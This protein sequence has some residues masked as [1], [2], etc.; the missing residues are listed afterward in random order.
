MTYSELRTKYP[1]FI[2]D[3]FEYILSGNKL[4]IKFHFS[5]PPDHEFTHKLS[6]NLPELKGLNELKVLEVL[7]F[8][9]G[10]SL[11]PSYWKTTC[12][13]IIEI[14]AKCQLTNDQMQFWKKLLI[15]G[16]GEYFYKNQIDFTPPNFLSIISSGSSLSTEH[17]PAGRQ[18]QSLTSNAQ[19]VLV[20]IGG[21]K[22]S[23]VTLELLK[24]HFTVT[25]LGINPHPNFQK[26]TEIAGVDL[27]TVTSE[28]DP[29]LLD[30]NKQGY[31]NGHV[32]VSAFYAFTACLA[33]NL[34]DIPSVVLS[35]ERSSNEGNT[36][37]LGHEINHQYSKS[38]EF[39]TDFNNYFKTFNYF[40][41][42]RPLYELQ[43]TK[44]FSNYPQYFNV[45]TSCN[46]NFK[47]MTDSQRPMTNQ[48]CSKCPKCVS[49]A[50]L[51]TPFIGKNKV[52]EIMGTYPP[53]LSENKNILDD[54]LGN[55][56]V[57]PFECVLT[58]AEAQAAYTNKNLDNLLSFWL[59]NPNM[60][61]KF[62]EIL[63]HALDS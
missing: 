42:L 41:F 28:I 31:L 62:T 58:R 37:Y 5:I 34:L 10:L 22:D 21:G 50:L 30:L 26:I 33:S 46:Q 27:L 13:P 63:K 12:S 60:P 3:K 35:N 49:T 44:L 24:K 56:P 59:P 7:I 51:L 48:W 47:L 40:S 25:A 2:Y 14:N 55:N 32:P 23:I 54:L 20:P 57:K 17:L 15:K 45:F 11:I 1:K 16:M 6:I 36:T 38:L 53:D 4:N 39:E 19:S 9:V 61:E 52:A 29:Y 8:N 18:A 43:I